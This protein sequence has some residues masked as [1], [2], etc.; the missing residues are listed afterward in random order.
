VIENTAN[1]RDITFEDFS[2][3]TLKLCDRLRHLTSR[4]ALLR[5]RLMGLIPGS[6]AEHLMFR[7]AIESVD[8]EIRQ[9][10]SAIDDYSSAYCR[11]D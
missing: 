4:Y 2:D 5:R 9:V 1:T 6:D 8:F 11:G 10:E 7:Q 3:P